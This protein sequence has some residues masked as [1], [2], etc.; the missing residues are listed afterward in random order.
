M[1]LQQ[2]ITVNGSAV[3]EIIV[4]VTTDAER[5]IALEWFWRLNRITLFDSINESRDPKTIEK[6]RR[7]TR[8]PLYVWLIPPRFLP[9]VNASNC[10]D[11]DDYMP[12]TFS[13]GRFAR[14]SFS[15][16]FLAQPWTEKE[17]NSR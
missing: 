7:E 3:F 15:I 16:F 6:E 12:T 2:Q 4:D 11:D 9:P 17:G 5:I 1:A 14:S 8:A 10:D 13:G